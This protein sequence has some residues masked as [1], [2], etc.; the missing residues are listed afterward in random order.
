MG[1][2]RVRVTGQLLTNVL[3]YPEDAHIVN[4]EYV[5]PDVVELTFSHKD[6]PKLGE[7]EGIP[8]TVPRV[9]RHP[10]RFEFD[11]GID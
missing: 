2:V 9:I 3:K 11:W 6:L 7:G 8:G 10:E 5:A 1:Y 4:C